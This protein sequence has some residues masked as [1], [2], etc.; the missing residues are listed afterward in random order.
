MTTAMVMARR[1]VV[2]EERIVTLPISLID[3][4]CDRYSLPCAWAVVLLLQ[5]E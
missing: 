1:T 3:I 4:V 5:L 2:V